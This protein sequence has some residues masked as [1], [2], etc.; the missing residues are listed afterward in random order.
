[1]KNK[2]S[3]SIMKLNHFADVLVVKKNLKYSSQNTSNGEEMKKKKNLK[4]CIHW[5]TFF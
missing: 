3:E 1:M 2:F 4:M 5:K